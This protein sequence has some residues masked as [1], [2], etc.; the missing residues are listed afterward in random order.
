[1]KTKKLSLHR[2]IFAFAA[3]RPIR[4][5]GLRSALVL[6]VICAIA[7][8]SASAQAFTSLAVFDQTNGL[9]P[10]GALVQALDGSFYGTTNSGGTNNGGLVYQWVPGGSP[11]PVYMFCKTKS[12]PTGADPQSALVLAPSGLLY[13]TAAGGANDNGGTVFTIT[14]T[15]LFHLLYSFCAQVNCP[16]GQN[17][18]TGLARA[19]D[20]NF[21]GAAFNGGAYNHGSIFRITPAGQVTVV[22]SFCPQTNCLDG[23]AP[24]APITQGA[25]GNLYGTT[26]GGGTADFNG[27]TVFELTK[28]GTLT[29][30][31]SFCSQTNCSDGQRPFAKLLLASDGNFYGTTSSG[32]THGGGTIF[33][34]TPQGTLTTLYKLCSLSNCADGFGSYSDLIQATD[35]KLYG[36]TNQGGAN[37]YGTIF[38][39]TTA[40]T[41]TTLHSFAGADGANPVGALVQGTDGILYGTTGSG[42]LVTT[43]QPNLG[44]C[45]TVFSLDMGLSPFVKFVQPWG[46]V[47]SS[48]IIQGTNLT[49]STSVTPLISRSF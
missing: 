18:D 31:Y 25:N 23:A 12:C 24:G 39:I 13:G 48:V 21:Y 30:L 11:N 3:R 47:G 46:K 44:G 17:L 2:A 20:N 5:G 40:G 6:S 33:R 34:I 32:G 38:Q 41:F 37:N 36:V 7:L 19:T 8:V 26:A 14:P 43:C 49:G 28:S 42:G 1:M 22:Y 16:D 27:G 29:T 9:G 45:G 35:G 10:G 4:I 15:G